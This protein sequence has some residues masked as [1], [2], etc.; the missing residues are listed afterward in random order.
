MALC[1]LCYLTFKNQTPNTI[2]SLALPLLF[3]RYN[4]FLRLVFFY[5]HN[6]YAEME[7]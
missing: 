1:Q 4:Y 3:S 6:N 5:S 7:Y 2:F